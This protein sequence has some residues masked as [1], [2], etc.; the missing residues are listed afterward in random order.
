MINRELFKK[1]LVK[2]KG[3]AIKTAR[4]DLVVF[5][6][7]LTTWFKLICLDRIIY[8]WPILNVFLVFTLATSILIF[9]PAFLFRKLKILF[10]VLVAFSASFVIW[11]NTV[12]YR[13]F[14]SLI[15]IESLA[16]AN[17][18]TDVSDSVVV[19]IRPNDVLYFLDIALIIIFI[20]I[21]KYRIKYQK[22]T[23]ERIATFLFFFIISA[24]AISGIFYRDRYDHLEK[25]IYRNFDINQIERRYGALGVHGINSYRYLFISN[26]KISTEREKEV[27]GWIKNNKV[28][29]STNELTGVAASKNV[30]L[31]QLESVQSFAVGKEFEG[32]EI[33]PNI[34]KLARQS[35]YYPNGNYMIG[36]GKTSDSDFSVNTSL[37]PLA[38]SSV[39]VQHAKHGFT[40]L[41]K[42]LAEGGYSSYAYHAY[43][44]DFW[45]RNLAFNSLGFDK[46]YAADNY[47]EGTNIIMGL[48]DVD[49]YKES[50]KKIKGKVG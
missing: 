1:Q 43:K 6:L 11:A 47:P 46:Y 5:L 39:F 16:I 17:Q 13:F 49:F 25:F 19:L 40:S 50:L 18:A 22:D 36:G 27:V 37:Y 30:F 2:I 21:Y 23:K 35:Y 15:K 33:T 3:L 8:D 12:Y 29:Q 9:S 48:N 7:I 31:I 24:L 41:P 42:A 28:G 44:R 45:N 34:N 38:D 32:Q 26:T 20:L 14:G 10:A 4:E